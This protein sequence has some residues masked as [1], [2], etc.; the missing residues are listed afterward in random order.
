M[1][2]EKKSKVGLLNNKYLSVLMAIIVLLIFYFAVKLIPTKTPEI[3]NNNLKEETDNSVV[4]KKQGTLSFIG[5]DGKV[6]SNIDVELADNNLKRMQG[7]MY[8]KEMAENQGMLFIFEIQDLQ[9]FWMKNTILSLD[10]LYINVNREIVKIHKNTTPFSTESYPSEK[11]AIYV[12][13][14][15]AGYTD[16]YGISE[17]DK[18]NWV[19]D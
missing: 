6:L 3:S 11:P 17:G 1:T 8:R 15:N 10:I 7:L 19:I 18:I 13:E 14:V 9:S 5:K 16:K 2:T 4:F 12:V